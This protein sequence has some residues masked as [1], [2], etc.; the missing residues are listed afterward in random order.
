M[1]HY[2]DKL[3]SASGYKYDLFS[4]ANDFLFLNELGFNF[5]NLNVN[6]YLAE[7]NV[8]HFDAVCGNASS[9]TKFC[10]EVNALV[11]FKNF[12]SRQDGSIYCHVCFLEGPFQDVDFKNFILSSVA[13]LRNMVL[14]TNTPITNLRFFYQVYVSV[15]SFRWVV[16]LLKVNYDTVPDPLFAEIIVKQTR[17]LEEAKVFFNKDKVSLCKELKLFTT[18]ETIHKILDTASHETVSHETV[19]SEIVSFESLAVVA[20]FEKQHKFD[21]VKSRYE[22]DTIM[23]NDFLNVMEVLLVE[24]ENVNHF[25]VTSRVLADV[26]QYVNEKFFNLTVPVEDI[27]SLSNET[28]NE[29]VETLTVFCETSEV[30][31]FQTFKSKSFPFN[32]IETFGFDEVKF[33]EVVSNALILTAT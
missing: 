6:L 27:S 10:G 13:K 24:N 33:K 17:R 1:P 32:Q 28:F 19:P 14:Y 4:Y 20:F 11:F 29:F 7:D 8:K 22:P 3:S 9:E 26:W 31:S 18:D 25:F 5:S 23:M 21:N 12:V 30:V 2:L 16:S 15:M